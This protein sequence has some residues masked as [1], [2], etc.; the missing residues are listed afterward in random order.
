[1]LKKRLHIPI[2]ERF[3]AIRD[4]LHV[5]ADALDLAQNTKIKQP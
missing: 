3:F 1:M 4:L 2:V 5:V